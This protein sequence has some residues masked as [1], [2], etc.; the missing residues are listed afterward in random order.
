M[1]VLG[2]FPDVRMRRMRRD[3]FSRRLMRENRLSVDDLIY[4]IFVIEGAGRTEAVASMPGVERVTIDRLL[5]IAEDCVALGIPVVALFPV[6][7][8]MIKTPDGIEAC[9]PDGLV[10]RAV[11]ALKARFSAL[12]LFPRHAMSGPHCSPTLLARSWAWPGFHDM[13]CR[14]RIEALLP[15]SSVRSGRSNRRPAV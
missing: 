15:S 13:R 9:N 3:D 8:P 12:I 11:S 10:P 4:P 7:D 6:I 2:R 14:G 1:N 5:P